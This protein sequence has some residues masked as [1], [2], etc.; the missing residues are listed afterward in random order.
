MGI[1]KVTTDYI[2]E[3]LAKLWPDLDMVVLLDKGFV[4]PK[5]QEIV[6]IFKASKIREM[7][8]IPEFNDC[9]DFALFLM[10]EVRM[11]RYEKYKNGGLT[12]DEIAPVAFGMA[13]GNVFR[14]MG[15]DHVVNICVTDEGIYLFD[16]TPESDRYWKAD[17]YTDNI[18]LCKM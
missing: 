8:F 16:I 7:E 12:K 5:L 1:K 2:R 13:V 11:R 6:D 3:E 15:M 17:S 4:L 14:G 10:A 9:D 18:L